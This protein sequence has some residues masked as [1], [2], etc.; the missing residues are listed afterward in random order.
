MEANGTWSSTKPFNMKFN[1]KHNKHLSYTV[2]NAHYNN[3]KFKH[4]DYSIQNIISYYR[5]YL[6]YK[7]EQN[8][9][10][11]KY[12]FKF[13]LIIPTFNKASYLIKI[14]IMYKCSL[15]AR[16]L[17]KFEGKA[18]STTMDK[19]LNDLISQINELSELYGEE[20][21]K[22]INLVI[23]ISNKIELIDL[24][25]ALLFYSLSIIDQ[26]VINPMQINS[27]L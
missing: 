1:Y 5:N 13:T 6:R 9:I 21:L 23:K 27:L 26:S 20:S 12:P 15:S 18:L 22:Y 16:L 24:I 3:F 19:Q 14:L 2:N 11:L 8:S 7:D 10:S 4:K 17:A 25:S